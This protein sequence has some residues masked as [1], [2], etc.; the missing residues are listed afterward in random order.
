MEARR[1]EIV[2]SCGVAADDPSCVSLVSAHHPCV[3][4]FDGCSFDDVS[5]AQIFPVWSQ[6]CRTCLW[7][8]AQYYN[9]KRSLLAYCESV[10]EIECFLSTPNIIKHRLHVWM[11]PC[12]AKL[13]LLSPESVYPL[14]CT[15]FLEITV[16]DVYVERN[17]FSSIF[18]SILLTE[19]SVECNVWMVS[20]KYQ[21]KQTPICGTISSQWAG[22]TLFYFIDRGRESIKS[23]NGI[24]EYSKC[25]R[26]KLFNKDKTK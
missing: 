19:R 10:I 1:I 13:F 18:F 5:S 25:E 12:C 21:S 2:K 15:S 8:I 24:F 4:T 6:T 7:M 9:W 14:S 16:I 3:Q 23:Q 11:Y 20:I 22:N 17:Y 26:R